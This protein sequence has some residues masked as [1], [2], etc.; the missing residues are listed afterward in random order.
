[1]LDP[2]ALLALLAK[3]V[4]KAPVVRLALLDV[5]VKLVPPAPPAP[6]VRKEPLVLTDPL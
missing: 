1:M 2:P 4:A 5:P 6:L 3:K